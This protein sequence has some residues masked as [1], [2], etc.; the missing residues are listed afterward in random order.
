[1]CGAD[2]CADPR[3]LSCFAREDERK[4]LGRGPV[5]QRKD[6]RG[7]EEKCIA[8]ANKLRKTQKVHAEQRTRNR[9]RRHAIRQSNASFETKHRLP[10]AFQGL[11]SWVES[12][13]HQMLFGE[14]KIALRF[15][16]RSRVGCIRKRNADVNAC[17]YGSGSSSGRSYL[18]G[19]QNAMP[20]CGNLMEAGVASRSVN[21][22]VAGNCS[23]IL[24]PC[25]GTEA[26]CPEDYCYSRSYDRFGS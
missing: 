6:D 10:A 16:T 23:I 8:A 13:A 11:P 12:V 9:L 14:N 1:M 22:M 24:L 17:C 25:N 15:C 5:H 2:L 19:P 20:V 26:Q 7:G 4:N 18:I 21:I 3:G